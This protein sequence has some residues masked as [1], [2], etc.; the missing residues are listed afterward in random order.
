[1]DAG[2]FV[3]E[4]YGIR[5]VMDPGNQNYHEL[6]KTG[7]DLWDRCQDC[8]RWTLL[9]KNNFGHSTLTIDG[10]LHKVDG[11]AAITDFKAG[12]TPEATI[13]LSPVFE[14]QLQSARRRFVKDSPTSLLVEDKIVL[15]EDTQVITWQLMTQAD[16]EIVNDGAILR[17]DGR[18]VKLENVS[19]PDVSFSVISM[20]MPPLKL[21][22]RIEGLKR[23]ELRFPAWLFEE[24]YGT[25]SIRIS[26][27]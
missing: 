2:S 14:R 15:T 13:D 26:G 21:D 18:Q 4:L 22:R 20:S 9:T 6:E 24:K 8:E 19:H 5:W 27:E 11:M 16:V 23:I 1:M 25:I 3:F 10:Q 7:F 12:D 17:K